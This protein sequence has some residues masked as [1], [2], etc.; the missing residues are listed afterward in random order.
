[1]TVDKTNTKPRALKWVIVCG[2]VIVGVVVAKVGG[3]RVAG[4]LWGT[5]PAEPK[6]EFA[7]D[8]LTFGPVLDS[9]QT[10]R[11]L[12]L[13]NPSAQAVIVERFE[14]SCSCL[15]GDPS[16]GF[17]IAPGEMKVLRLK[18]RGSIPVNRQPNDDGLH[19]ETVNI[20]AVYSIANGKPMRAE[21][22][23]RYT[24]RADLRIDPSEVAVGVVSHREPLTVKTKL[25]LYPPV[26]AVRV[27][28][29]PLW[30]VSISGEGM[31]RELVAVPTKLGVPRK[32]DETIHLI[33]IS[34][35]KL[36]NPVKSFRIH[37][38]IKPDITS[39]PADVSIGRVAV[40]KTPEESFRLVSQTQRRFEVT[41]VG[42][43]SLDATILTDPADSFGFV[44][45]VRATAREDQERKVWVKVKQDDG[46]E[47]TVTIPVRY[48]GE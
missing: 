4:W 43:E 27:K 18:L 41:Q 24:I 47:L 28:P 26:E 22:S 16:G 7:A 37:G 44:V 11:E 36:D 42:S 40:G 21:A 39:S 31:T 17:V 48:Y 3:D 10:E 32:L 33:P 8:D 45:R 9:E 25:I 1:V 19:T 23:I 12:R 38:E 6:L 15:V 14:T 30:V 29:H 35:N 13:T 2:V 46:S 20:R 5:P 34:A